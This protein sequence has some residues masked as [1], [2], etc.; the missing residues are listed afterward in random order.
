MF[1]VIKT[2][3]KQYKVEVGSLLKVEKLAVEVGN[4]VTIEEVLMVGDKVGTPFVNGA[5]VVAEVKEQGK[6]K[7]VI[8]F[9][10]NKKTYYRKK[11]HR[12]QYTLI[13]V[14]DIKG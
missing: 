12:Q 2:G 14:K 9:K 11:G 5:K 10:Y 3:G 7:K 1:A 8:N 13:E 4:E 6:G